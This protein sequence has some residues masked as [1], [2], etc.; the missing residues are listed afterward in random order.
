[1]IKKRNDPIRIPLAV[2]KQIDDAIDER[3]RRKLITRKE[4]TYPKAMELIGRT[5]EFNLA[6]EKFKKLPKKE[7]L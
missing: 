3:L 6:I 7:D 5:P 2:R 1:M 4:A